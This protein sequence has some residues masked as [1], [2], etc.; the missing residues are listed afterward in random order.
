LNTFAG[1]F[2]S[3]AAEVARLI[4][5]SVEGAVEGERKVAVAFSGGLDSSVIAV[6][7]AKHTNVV[8]CTAFAKNSG[9]AAKAKEAAGAMGLPSIS[10]ELTEENVGSALA[11]IDLAFKPTL[12]DRSLWCLFRVVSGCARRS[13]VRVML[14]GQLADEMFGGY[15]KYA[16]ALKLKGVGAVESMMGSD[17]REYV[18]RGRVRDVAACGGLVE[19]RFPFEAKDLR[20]FAASLPVSFKIQN[21]ERKAVLRRAAVIIGVPERVASTPKKAAQY[22][23]GVQKLLTSS[24]SASEK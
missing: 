22:S 7:A 5:H 11:A 24:R 14:L 4:E 15:A 13:G 18:S 8:V 1:D 12:M 9:D 2:E 23:S 16:E 20:E 3:A 21:G 19:P 17:L 10:C 6:S